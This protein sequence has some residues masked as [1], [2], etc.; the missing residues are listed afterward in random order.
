MR[1]SIFITCLLSLVFSCNLPNKG[2]QEKTGLSIDSLQ[3]DSTQK[4][5][6]V[7]WARRCV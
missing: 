4:H 2:I 3:V 7:S 5:I 1:V 6:L